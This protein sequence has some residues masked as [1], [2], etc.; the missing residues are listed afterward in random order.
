M[1]KGNMARFPIV[2]SAAAEGEGAVAH[3]VGEALT[4]ERAKGPIWISVPSFSSQYLAPRP[5]SATRLLNYR[6]ASTGGGCSR[7]R[8]RIMILE[9]HFARW[10]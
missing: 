6:D 1:K 8:C 4:R 7:P 9:T 3:D 5:N 10:V 2:P